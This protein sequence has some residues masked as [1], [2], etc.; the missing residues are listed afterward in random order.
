VQIRK[1]MPDVRMLFVTMHLSPAYLEAALSAGGNGYVLKS[2]AREELLTAVEEVLAGHIYITPSLS[3]EQLDNSMSPEQ[4]AAALRLTERE[5]ETL[6]LI[7]EGHAAKQIAHILD[8]SIKTVA[9]HRENLK[10]KLNLRTTAEL[11]KYALEQ[12]LISN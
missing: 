4:A 5:R 6:Q 7:A 2:A 8:I 10:K 1:V 9:F 11:T 3:N 12:G